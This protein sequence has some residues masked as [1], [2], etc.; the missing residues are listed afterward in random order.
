V[1]TEPDVS[2]GHIL[3]GRRQAID[4]GIRWEIFAAD[5]GVAPVGCGLLTFINILEISPSVSHKS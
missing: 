1:L 2:T 5:F 4:W 3:V